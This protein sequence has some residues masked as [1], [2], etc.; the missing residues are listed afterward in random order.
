MVYCNVPRCK[1]YAKTTLQCRVPTTKTAYAMATRR[2]REQ[3]HRA[4]RVRLHVQADLQAGSSKYFEP[5]TIL[6]EKYY[7]SYLT[8]T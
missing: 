8:C 7:I 2:C 4:E 5:N 6:F 1:A 3:S